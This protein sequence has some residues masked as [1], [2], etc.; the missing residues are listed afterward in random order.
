MSSSALHAV[1]AVDPA[2]FREQ[3]IWRADELDG[4]S[5]AAC[6][7]G[8]A[9][10]DAELPGGGWP[11]GALTELLQSEPTQPLWPLLLPALALTVAQRPSA[12]VVLVAPPLP[13]FGPALAAGG[14]PS[15]ALLCVQAQAAAERLWASEQALRCADVGAV[16]VWLPQSRVADLRRLQLAA[17][18]Q[19][20]LL[21]ALR[22]SSQAQQASPA[23][24]RLA[25]EL[26][27]APADAPALMSLQLLKRR[28]PPAVR[29]VQVP[30][31]P[32][33]LQALLA[34]AHAR[35]QVLAPSGAAA[36]PVAGARVLSWPGA[37]GAGPSSSTGHALDRPSLVGA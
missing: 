16:L 13:P 7:T 23:R 8:H 29:P 17:A 21:F 20:G 2:A 33:P 24:L 27:P 37:R 22:P 26:L 4:S 14:L 32:L 1:S 10:L 11:L 6:S 30:A 5:E 18:R 36:A 15:A 35:R 9:A 25:M 3:G 19:G 28:G 12:R 31:Q 34:A